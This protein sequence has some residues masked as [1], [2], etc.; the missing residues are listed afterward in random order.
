MEHYPMINFGTYRLKEH[1]INISLE[2]AFLN[3][4]RSIDTASL[5]NNEKFIGNYITK[6]EI[7]RNS[8][9]LTSKL[10]PKI[11]PKSEDSII[12]SILSTFE[13]LQTNYLDLYLIPLFNNS[14][15][16]VYTFF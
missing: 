5:Y 7:S 4:Y 14:Y 13:D 11:I 10:S 1:N 2:T 3:G 6:N 16:L 12:K 15:F 8:I 9:W